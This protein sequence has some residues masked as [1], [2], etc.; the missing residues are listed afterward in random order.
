MSNS[1][2]IASK[3]VLKFADK[4]KNLGGNGE[5]L[6]QREVVRTT[7]QTQEAIVDKIT[8]DIEPHNR[9]GKTVT[10]LVDTGAYRASWQV[11]FPDPMTG[12]VSTNIEYAPALEYGHDNLP[13]FYV[14]RDTA[15]KMRKQFVQN[16]KKAMVE[17][18][19]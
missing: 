15:R 16:I 7:L 4:L 1:Y 14:A 13:G 6:L 3:Q 19:K 17:A 5:K 9:D 10:D 18:V 12:K 11:S 8:N 2:N